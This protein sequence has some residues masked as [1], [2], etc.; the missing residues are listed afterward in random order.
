MTWHPRIWAD[1]QLWMH[2]MTA[3]LQCSKTADNLQHARPED[4]E[5]WFRERRRRSRWLRPWGRWSSPGGR[6]RRRSPRCRLR[7]RRWQRQRWDT[8]C[9]WLQR[10]TVWP[11]W[12]TND[13][14]RDFSCQNVYPGVAV[15]LGR[16]F[17]EAKMSHGVL[18]RQGMLW[19]NRRWHALSWIACSTY[20]AHSSPEP[21]RRSRWRRP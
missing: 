20:Q 4:R 15:S 21:Q 8:H 19:Q 16:C 1:F 5:R 14:A 13:F 11:F 12:E 18:V 2:W 10:I 3:V 6:L 17:S 9:K 7:F